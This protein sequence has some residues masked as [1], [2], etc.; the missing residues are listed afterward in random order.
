VGQITADVAGQVVG[1]F[2]AAFAVFFERLADD[3]VEFT[4]AGVGWAVPTSRRRCIR[5]RLLVSGAHPTELG[6]PRTYTFRLFFADDSL[7]FGEAG[8]AE[9]AGFERS[10][11]GEQFVEKHA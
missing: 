5:V 9:A 7:H 6:D 3:P 10:R 8:F 2:V 4:E 11:A 1:R